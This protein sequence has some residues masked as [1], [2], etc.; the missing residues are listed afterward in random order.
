MGT[1]T[2]EDCAAYWAWAAEEARKPGNENY[3]KSIRQY[4]DFCAMYAASAQRD[5]QQTQEAR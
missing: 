5:T 4:Q 2:N 3:R 1:K